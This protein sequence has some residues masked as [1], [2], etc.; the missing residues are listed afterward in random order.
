MQGALGVGAVSHV[1]AARAEHMSDAKTGARAPSKAGGPPL[2][3]RVVD[4][5]DDPRAT[6]NN[7]LDLASAL[8]RTPHMDTQS[9]VLLG[10]TGIGALSLYALRGSIQFAPDVDQPRQPRTSDIDDVEALARVIE[11]EVGSYTLREKVVVAWAV[12]NRARARHESIARLVCSPTCGHQAGR[13]FSSYQ[14]ATADTRGIARV[15][16]DADQADDPTHG[17]WAILEPA[18][19]ERE[20]LAGKHKLSLD[21]LRAQWEHR[22]KLRVFGTVGRIE[23]W[24]HA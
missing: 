3:A 16:V 13:T 15:V 2:L 21:E 22:D 4:E 5:A 17:A 8:A 1:R 7:A 11:S 9:K 23:L 20:Y 14:Q 10:L 12:R 6:I 19:Y 18:L 24:G